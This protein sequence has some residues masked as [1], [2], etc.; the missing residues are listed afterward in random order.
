MIQIREALTL[1][2][3]EYAQLRDLMVAVVDDGASI[4]YLRPM[5]PD[6]AAAYWRGVLGPNR[7]L[8]LA[9]GPDGRIVGTAQLGLEPRPNGRHRAEVNKLMVHP[10]ARR[11]GL[12]RRLML[13]LET[14]ALREHRTLLFLDT[15]EGDPSNDL[16][17][18]LGYT[19]AGRIP[20]YVRD[21]NGK[22][23]ATVIYYKSLA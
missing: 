22:R 9:E 14:I 15:R 20:D 1:T 11:Q 6:E 4:G 17:L 12:A 3:G 19:E 10:D 5:D 8:L 13:E 23:E 21:E 18:G 16:Y 2:P 7:V